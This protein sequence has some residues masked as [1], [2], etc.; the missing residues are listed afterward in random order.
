MTSIESLGSLRWP[1]LGVVLVIVAVFSGRVIS[2]RH[3][4]PQSLDDVLQVARTLHLFVHGDGPNGAVGTRLILSETNPDASE[5]LHVPVVNSHCLHHHGKVAVYM[6]HPDDV[7]LL[8]TQPE[9]AVIW[10]RY[11]V[12]GDAGLIRRLLRHQ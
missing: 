9:N 10:G 1:F 8:Q 11:F 3:Q 4:Q 2:L 12:Y 6:R 7:E 5:L